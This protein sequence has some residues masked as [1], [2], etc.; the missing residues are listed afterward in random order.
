MKYL[1]YLRQVFLIFFALFCFKGFSQIKKSETI[2]L[3]PR[4]QLSKSFIDKTVYENVQKILEQ[5]SV[6]DQVFADDLIIQGSG[7]FGF[8]CVNGESFNFDTIRLKENN[9]RIGFDDTSTGAFPANDW[10]IEV[11]ESAS[12]GLSSF[13]I[14]D[15]TGSKKPFSI[16]A[17]AKTNALYVDNTGRIGIGTNSPVLNVDILSGNTP[18]IRLNQDNSSGFTAQTWDMAGNEANFFIRDVT[19]GSR[20][21]FRIRPGAPTSSIDIQAN[22]TIKIVNA[23]V[24]NSDIRLKKNFEKIENATIII[25]QLN[26]LKYDFKYDELKEMGLPKTRQFGL[27]AQELELVLPELVS[28]FDN[29]KD[30]ETYKGINYTGLIPILIKGMQEQQAEIENL[31]AK[32]FNY[33]EINS[34][35]ARL[36]AMLNNEEKETKAGKKEEK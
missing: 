2:R 10:E 9:L 13:S 7:C 29:E 32:L 36:E 14:R 20:L 21:P 5:K 25:Q 27:I 35:L 12:G 16:E 34:R 17:G 4:N 18:A 3:E 23:I 6:M 24:P 22:G 19:G 28:Q 8:D 15:I 31:K 30:K 1:Y 26:P 11:N 33:E